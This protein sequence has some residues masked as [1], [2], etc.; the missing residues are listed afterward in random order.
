MSGNHVY[1]IRAESLYIDTVA[2]F[3]HLEEGGEGRGEGSLRI[4]DLGREPVKESIW[5]LR[6]FRKTGYIQNSTLFK[7]HGETQPFVM[8]CKQKPE[9]NTSLKLHPPII[10]HPFIHRAS[11]CVVPPSRSHNPVFMN[12]PLPQRI[13]PATLTVDHAPLF[14]TDA[15]DEADSAFGSVCLWR[16]LLTPKHQCMPEAWLAEIRVALADI[17]AVQM[18]SA[19]DGTRE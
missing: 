18:A 4:D 19:A 2:N 3:C 6:Y 5:I 8:E 1:N 10:G 13:L 14:H 12:A 15:V 17:D 9:R 16:F 7:E 11:R